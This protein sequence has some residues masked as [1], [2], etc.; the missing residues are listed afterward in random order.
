MP[1]MDSVDD[2]YDNATAESFFATL[3]RELLSR[4]HF[5][6][7]IEAKMAVFEWIEGWYNSHRR[8]SARGY[9]SPAKY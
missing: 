3:E 5:N 6:S 2:A 8:H 7:E 9:R 4:R 1:S